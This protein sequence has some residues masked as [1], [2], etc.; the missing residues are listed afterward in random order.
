[1]DAFTRVG[2]YTGWLKQVADGFNSDDSEEN[3]LDGSDFSVSD[4]ETD[5]EIAQLEELQ[6]LLERLLVFQDSGYVFL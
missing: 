2:Y 3:L 1:M 5:L 4:F 6:R